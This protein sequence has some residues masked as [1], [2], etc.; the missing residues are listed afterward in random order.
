MS[1]RQ[2][3]PASEDPPLI[4]Q[5]D[6]HLAKTSGFSVSF[7][8]SHAQTVLPGRTGGHRPEFV[9]ILRNDVNLIPA[10]KKYTY[11]IPSDIMLRVINLSR[12]RQQVGVQEKLHSPRPS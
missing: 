4:Q 1:K 5:Q 2:V 9:E 10:E 8:R 12:S 3:L 7:R 11:G 6:E